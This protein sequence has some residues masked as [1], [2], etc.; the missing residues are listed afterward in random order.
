MPKEIKLFLSST[1]DEKMQ[2][3]RDYFRN[4]IYGLNNK[5]GIQHFV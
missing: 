4:E 3:E 1:F 2:G 5:N